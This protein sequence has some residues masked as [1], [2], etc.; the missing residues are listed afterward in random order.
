[1]GGV[2][3]GF[4]EALPGPVRAGVWLATLISLGVAS[5]LL[6]SGLGVAV[7]SR[8]AWAVLLAVVVVKFVAFG[9]WVAV[10][11]DFFPALCDQAAGMALIGGLAVWGRWRLSSTWRWIAVGLAAGVV[12]AIVQQGG[13]GL[14]AILNHNVIYHFFGAMTLI[15]FAWV[16]RTFV[17]RTSQT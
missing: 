9:I 11:G 10:R 2:A 1:M 13:I 7:L 3:H 4:P 17:D 12:G 6:V 16:G 5:A 15:A 14:G 8:R